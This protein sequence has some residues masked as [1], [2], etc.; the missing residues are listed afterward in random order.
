MKLQVIIHIN[1]NCILTDDL[2]HIQQVAL[3]TK[4]DI[5]TEITHLDFSASDVRRIA[6]L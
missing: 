4:W 2:N 1:F 5:C 3:I 6:E